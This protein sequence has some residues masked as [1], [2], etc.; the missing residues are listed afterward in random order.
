M[1]RPGPSERTDMHHPGELRVQRRAGVTGIAHGS[2]TLGNVIPAVAEAFLLEQRMIVISGEQDGASWTTALVGEPGFITTTA[3]STVHIGA[4][5]PTVDP[6]YGAFDAPAAIGMIAMEPRTRR[7][8]RINGRA[9]MGDNGLVVRADQVVANCPKY[10]ST[11]IVQAAVQT[12]A[13]RRSDAPVLS[14]AQLRW[15]RA[16]DTFFVGTGARGVG[17]DASHRGGNPG[18][19]EAAPGRLSWPD[20]LGNSMYLTLGNLDLDPRASLLFIDFHTGN[21]LHLTGTARVDWDPVRAGRHV[22]VQRFVDMDIERV[23]QL[24]HRIA[25][26]WELQRLSKFNPPIGGTTA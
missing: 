7:R 25:L 21:T 9:E 13:V 26:R 5:L 20:Y 24:D 17:Y 19:L 3:G 14:E 15:V 10:I 11:R 1:R 6:L 23:V 2:A 16:A 12:P 22:G 4:H 18:F 8:M